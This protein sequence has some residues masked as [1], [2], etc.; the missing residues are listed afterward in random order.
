MNRFI[1]IFFVGFQ[2]IANADPVEWPECYCTD[3]TGNRVE[4]GQQIC[5]QVDGRSY[6][7]RCE[8]SL[9]VPMWREVSTNECVTS[10]RDLGKAVQ[11]LQSALLVHP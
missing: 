8:M 11:P 3:R 4:L 5:M 6:T 10:S 1:L 7:A 2:G 9:N